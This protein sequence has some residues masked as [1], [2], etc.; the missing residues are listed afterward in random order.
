LKLILGIAVYIA[1]LYGILFQF[2][3]QVFSKM[4]LIN[5]LDMVTLGITDL[6]NEHYSIHC[7]LI[8]EGVIQ[9]RS[10][11]KISREST[12]DCFQCKIWWQQD[13]CS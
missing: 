12:N 10:S 5:M 4:Q 7:N 3:K 8:K 1:I 11:K 6:Q 9:K 13:K 2:Q